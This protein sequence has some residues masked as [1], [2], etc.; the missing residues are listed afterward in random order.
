MAASMFQQVQTGRV[1]HKS[2]LILVVHTV[3]IY[4]CMS[5]E[6]RISKHGVTTKPYPTMK[7]CECLYIIIDL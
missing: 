2:E 6:L 7:L 3:V 4:A 5:Q 1:S